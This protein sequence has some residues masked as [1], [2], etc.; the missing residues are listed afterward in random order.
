[1]NDARLQKIK[2]GHARITVNKLSSTCLKHH[3]EK[4]I[5]LHWS[6]NGMRI[7][8]TSKRP[9]TR[10]L[11]PMQI[12]QRKLKIPEFSVEFNTSDMVDFPQYQRLSSSAA[13]KLAKQRVMST[14][15]KSSK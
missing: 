7:I 5:S 10:L 14:K 13:A 1:M 3:I 6:K 4:L 11:R 8:T 12:P 9:N 15:L 2:R